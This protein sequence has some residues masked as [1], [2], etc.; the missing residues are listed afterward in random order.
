MQVKARYINSTHG[1]VKK[2]FFLN[3]NTSVCVLHLAVLIFCQYFKYK[4]NIL[5]GFLNGILP[6]LQSLVKLVR[7]FEK[8]GQGLLTRQ[9][10]RPYFSRLWIG[11]CLRRVGDPIK[12][13][14][15]ELRERR[16]RADVVGG[17]VVQLCGQKHDSA[18]QEVLGSLLLYAQGFQSF[19]ESLAMW[20][21]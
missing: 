12:A 4:R 1:N 11:R 6:L 10:G 7:H 9:E 18:S 5:T 14:P 20:K 15:E 2:T 8:R 13:E 16:M 17:W 3:A 19:A 21:I